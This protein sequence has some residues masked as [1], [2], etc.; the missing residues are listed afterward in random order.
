MTA[1]GFEPKPK[2]RSENPVPHAL[3]LAASF[4][5]AVVV[6]VFVCV[7]FLNVRYPL[8]RSAVASPV[9]EMLDMN[10]AYPH[11][12]KVTIPSAL[13]HAFAFFKCSQWLWRRRQRRAGNRPG[14]D[15]GSP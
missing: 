1:R 8:G 3:I 14:G 5:C 12:S 4:W 6:Y 7:I 11:L 15:D 10:P 9:Y 2:K 13:I